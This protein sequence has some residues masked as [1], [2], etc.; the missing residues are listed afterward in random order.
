MAISS[1]MLI[2]VLRPA[3]DPS[4]GSRGRP[5]REPGVR[6]AGSARPT[7]S[8]DA[9]RLGPYPASPGEPIRTR[10]LPSR[11]F[12]PGNPWIHLYDEATGRDLDE[13]ALRKK[14]LTDAAAMDAAV[15]A[16]RRRV[17]INWKVRARRRDGTALAVAL[18]DVH[19]AEVVL[20]DDVMREVQALLG[21]EAVAAAIPARGGMVVQDAMPER[22][23]DL[24]RL[25]AWAKQIYDTSG[26]KRITPN[27]VVCRDGVLTSTVRPQLPGEIVAAQREDEDDLTLIDEDTTNLR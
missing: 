9:R 25:M 12:V 18:V 15:A 14:G 26:D 8:P 3:D 24:G 19:A 13:A 22:F 11:T 27:L 16:L 21:V 6:V 20:L 1:S 2:P 17:C 4:S 7:P 5:D 10:L 23:D